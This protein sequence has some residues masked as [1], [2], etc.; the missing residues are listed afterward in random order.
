MT[1]STDQFWFTRRA[2]QV[3]GPYPGA[4][5]TRYILLGR[6]QEADE[7]SRDRHDWRRLADHPELIPEG[8]R[9]PDSETGRRRLAAA[10]R[11]ADERR[12]IDRRPRRL[13]P[14]RIERRNGQRRRVMPLTHPQAGAVRRPLATAALMFGLT[15]LALL[16]V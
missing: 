15:G 10:R 14:P 3:R 16:L 5:I 11:R 13:A 2:G 6:L 4:E 8:M 7:I 12:G 9:E 1:A